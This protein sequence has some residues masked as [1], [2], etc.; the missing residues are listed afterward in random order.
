M[1]FSRPRKTVPEL[2]QQFL[3]LHDLFHVFIEAVLAGFYP[4]I[5]VFLR[6]FDAFVA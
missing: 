2:C 3:R 6:D 4:W 1:C 5:V